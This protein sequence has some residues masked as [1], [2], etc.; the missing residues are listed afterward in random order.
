M[1]WYEAF[2]SVDLGGGEGVTIYM[3]IHTHTY[4]HTYIHTYMH[5]HT[6][7]SDNTWKPV[8]IDQN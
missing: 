1:R 6:F 7:V 4:I 3:Y 8:Y 2:A 5:I